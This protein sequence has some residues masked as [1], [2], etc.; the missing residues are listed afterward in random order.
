MTT[1]TPNPQTATQRLLPTPGRYVAPAAVQQTGA[2]HGR[3]P[4]APISPTAAPARMHDV[5]QPAS[6]SESESAVI[7]NGIASPASL[8]PTVATTA[9]DDSAFAIDPQPSRSKRSRWLWLP[10][11]LALIAGL[12]ALA[13]FLDDDDDGPPPDQGPTTT[14]ALLQEEADTSIEDGTEA[15][16]I[17]TIPGSALRPISPE[18]IADAI[19]GTLRN[20]A[21]IDATDL[22][23]EQIADAIGNA[24]RDQ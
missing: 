1:R 11:L 2:R 23:P 20:Q 6:G 13:L 14:S 18:A 4:A 21:A 9:T 19:S 8:I 15:P 7:E 16:R 3:P 10:L 22:T 5:S 24:L 12:V 17:E